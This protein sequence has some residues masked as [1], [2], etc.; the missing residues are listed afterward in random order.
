MH[1]LT[2]R[3]CVFC[4]H[5]TNCRPARLEGYLLKQG[6]K[7]SSK[8]RRRWFSLQGRELRYYTRKAI[9]PKRQQQEQQRQQKKFDQA[10]IRNDKIAL[11]YSM[12]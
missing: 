1:A 10:E 12:T 5:E 11:E 2:P 7:K 8:F 4:T 9:D 3:T 6:G